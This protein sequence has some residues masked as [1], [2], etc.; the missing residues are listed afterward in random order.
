M[1]REYRDE[2][3]FPYRGNWVTLT[4]RGA[5]GDSRGGAALSEDGMSLIVRAER[6]EEARRF[7]LFF[8]TARTEETIRE[9]LPVW[10]KKLGARPISASVKYA[11]TRWGSCS[12]DGRLFF[13]SRL[14]MLS[15][16]VAEYIV[17]HELCHLKQMNHSRAFWDCVEAA[18][19][20]CRALRRKL[21]IEGQ[22]AQL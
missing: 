22:S 20:T 14:S 8:Y 18:L 4:L 7:V 1:S 5:D 11:K 16:D 2:E 6:P 9:L 21:R 12:S 15:D 19:P 17:V 13:N 10:S 3:K